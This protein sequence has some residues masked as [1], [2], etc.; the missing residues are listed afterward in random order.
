MAKPF[1]DKV[2]NAMVPIFNVENMSFNAIREN[3]IL[4]KISEFTVC[5]QFF[6]TSISTWL[7][8]YF[9]LFLLGL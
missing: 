6:V 7:E 9:E 2:N 5:S 1:S 3:K 4:P 8:L